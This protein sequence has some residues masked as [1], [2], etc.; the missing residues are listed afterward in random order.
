M[1]SWGFTSSGRRQATLISIA[2]T[3]MNQGAKAE[4]FARLIQ[5]HPTLPEALKEA[6]LDVRGM[7]IHLPRPLAWG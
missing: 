5:V 4:E 7:A 2:S 1:R 6:V 3:V